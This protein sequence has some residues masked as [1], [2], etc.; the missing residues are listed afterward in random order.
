MKL[1]LDLLHTCR[2]TILLN[3]VQDNEDAEEEIYPHTGKAVYDKGQNIIE[4]FKDG[5]DRPVFKLSEDQFSRIFKVEEEDK[6]ELFDAEYAI[7]L[8]VGKAPAN[9]TSGLKPLG[10]NMRNR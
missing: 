1:N 7:I 10:F 2:F 6:E 4:I 9:N 8:H 3:I 5:V